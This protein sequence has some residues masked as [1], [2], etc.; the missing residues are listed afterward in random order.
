LEVGSH[1]FQTLSNKSW[2]DDLSLRWGVGSNGACWGA[3]APTDGEEAVPWQACQI[4]NPVR[5][6]PTQGDASWG[7]VVVWESN[8]VFSSVADTGDDALKSFT[9]TLNKYGTGDTVTLY[10]RGSATVFAMHDES[11][12]WA[13]YTGAVNR[14]WRYVQVKAEY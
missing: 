2:I 13:L 12:S 8:P 14:A 7:K 6:A 4:A 10:I 1:V 3:S 9:A 5:S 11:P